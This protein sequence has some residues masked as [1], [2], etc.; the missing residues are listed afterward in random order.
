MDFQSAD[1]QLCVS[2]RHPR[3]IPQVVPIGID[4]EREA[5]HHSPG[6]ADDF[7]EV[8][9]HQQALYQRFLV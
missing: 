8:F 1:L 9:V 6:V 2:T 4:V 7:V 5:F 3:T